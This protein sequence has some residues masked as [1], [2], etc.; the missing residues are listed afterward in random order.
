MTLIHKNKLL[1][2]AA[3]M[4]AVGV[5]GL[6]LASTQSASA[7]SAGLHSRI[8]SSSTIVVGIQQNQTLFTANDICAARVISTAA[9]AI[10]LSFSSAITPSGTEGHVQA[11]STT[12]VYPAEQYGCGAVT[13][14]GH[15]GSTTI[16]KSEF[17]Y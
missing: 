6:L 11:A 5:I 9:E 17:F 2:A 16:T 8:A 10:M 12:V 7:Q 13:A 15:T 3:I 1:F 14:Y 4:F